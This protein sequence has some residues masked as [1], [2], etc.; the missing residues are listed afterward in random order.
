MS[1]TGQ[2]RKDLDF[3]LSNTNDFGETVTLE[4][5]D[6]LTTLEISGF[7]TKHRNGYDAEGVPANVAQISV[8]IPEQKLIDNAYPYKNADDQITFDK[9]KISIPEASGL[10]IK[11]MCSQWYPDR[12]LGCIV[13]FLQ[14]Y[15]TEG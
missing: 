12:E 8:A 9:H 2:A 13:I 6:G 5:P 14:D 1:I 11:Y 10:I 4:T 3:F 15:E 7:P